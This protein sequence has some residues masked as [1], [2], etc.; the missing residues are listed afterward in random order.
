MKIKILVYLFLLPFC[1]V[2]SNFR[3]KSINLVDHKLLKGS[4]DEDFDYKLCKIILEEGVK[5]QV[6]SFSRN[7]KND[8]LEHRIT[9][10][11]DLICKKFTKI[12]VVSIETHAGTQIDIIRQHQCLY[13]FDRN[14]K[15]LG[16]YYIGHEVYKPFRII[17]ST[18]IVAHRYNDCHVKTKINFYDSIPSFLYIHCTE[19][20][21]DI[22][23]FSKLE[24]K[25]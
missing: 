19:K 22:Y 16:V 3:S 14:N 20:G 23:N 1:F 8:F 18:L 5:N 9:Y 15:A 21:G 2:S 13:L 6:Y 10:V 7:K 4:S 25:K 12:K 11:G 24:S 17:K